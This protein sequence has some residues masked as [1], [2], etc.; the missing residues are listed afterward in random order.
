M[1]EQRHISVVLHLPESIHLQ[2]LFFFCPEVVRR[3]RKY[4]QRDW[5]WERAGMKPAVVHV[6]RKHLG[7]W[8]TMT[9]MMMHSW[10]ET[11]T[12][13][14]MSDQDHFQIY[15]KMWFLSKDNRLNGVLRLL[16]VNYIVAQLEHIKVNFQRLQYTSVYCIFLPW[17]TSV[18][19]LGGANQS[20]SDPENGGRTSFLC[21]QHLCGC[22]VNTAAA[23][24]P[25]RAPWI[26]AERGH[27]VSQ[28]SNP[29]PG[30]AVTAAD[31]HADGR[32][33]V[34]MCS[35]GGDSVLL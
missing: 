1:S 25:G 27:L 20:G 22:P 34:W 35:E 31:K 15:I 11:D 9:M 18:R 3:H 5:S 33:F 23:P 10:M 26:V 29:S 24:P 16:R 12:Q 21:S 13:K 19:H 30:W 4:N 2:I 8:M 32:V 14:N 28:E 7:V 6:I 17:C